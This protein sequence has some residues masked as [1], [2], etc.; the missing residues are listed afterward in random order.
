MILMKSC[1]VT[2]CPVLV[3]AEKTK[4]AGAASLYHALR[5]PVGGVT[6]T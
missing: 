4:A 5:E 3:I 6:V 2:A 1:P